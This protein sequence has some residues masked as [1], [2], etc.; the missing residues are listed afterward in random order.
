MEREANLDHINIHYCVHLGV[1]VFGDWDHCVDLG[2][3]LASRGAHV[4]HNRGRFPRTFKEHGFVQGA[5]LF[6]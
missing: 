2:G 6:V 3:E 1:L 5:T 4:E